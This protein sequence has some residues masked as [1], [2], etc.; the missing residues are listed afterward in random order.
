MRTPDFLRPRRARRRRRF[1]LRKV[2]IEISPE[3]IEL[4]DEAACRDVEAL[5]HDDA[6]FVPLFHDGHTVFIHQS[7]RGLADVIATS[8]G[9]FDFSLLAI[10][11]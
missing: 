3:A 4:L 1:G 7:V 8:S 2:S 10:D 11:D 5:L 6:R 9:A